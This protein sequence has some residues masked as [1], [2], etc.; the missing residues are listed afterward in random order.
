MGV[1]TPILRKKNKVRTK[2]MEKA[3]K[4]RGKKWII[5]L[6]SAPMYDSIAVYYEKK[7]GEN[8]YIK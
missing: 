4:I 5:C 7:K 8:D 6:I 3:Q 2:K 1:S